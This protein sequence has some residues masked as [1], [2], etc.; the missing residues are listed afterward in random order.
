LKPLFFEDW[1]RSAEP[2]GIAE[3]R[4]GLLYARLSDMKWK[5]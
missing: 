4:S 2:E 5:K 1:Q 3:K